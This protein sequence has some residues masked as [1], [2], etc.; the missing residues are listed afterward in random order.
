M[1]FHLVSWQLSLIKLKIL[2]ALLF[3]LPFIGLR[4]MYSVISILAPSSSLNPIGGA[5]GLRIGLSFMPELISVLAYIY[6]GLVT[7]TL[8][9]AVKTVNKRAAPRT[10]E[11]LQTER[12]A[13]T[14][15]SEG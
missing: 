9:R 2:Y 12:G 5:I 13:K 1:Y 8:N 7:H 3:S 4:M 11:N 6:A 10:F 15:S 14:D